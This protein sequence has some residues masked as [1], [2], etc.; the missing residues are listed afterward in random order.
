M[1]ILHT[2]DWHLGKIINEF[3]MLEDQAYIL[4]QLKQ[5][6]KEKEVDL[7]VIAGD[8]YDRSIP[9]TGAVCLF[10]Q[11]LSEVLIGTKLK[12]AIIPGNHDGNTR[13]SFGSILLKES[14]L[15][16]AGSEENYYEKVE[17]NE[18]YDLYLFP[19][20]DPIQVRHQLND[21]TITSHQSA[22][23]AI[24]KQID[25]NQQKKNI[26]AYH[27][28]VYKGKMEVETSE[29]ERPLAVGGTDAVNVSV[30]N[31]FEQVYLGHLHGRQQLVENKVM[32]SGSPLKYSF[33]EVNQLKGVYVNELNKTGI[34]SEFHKLEPLRDM[35]IIRGELEELIN[36][37]DNRIS[38]Y[39]KVE[40]TDSNDI[41]N[42][43]EKIRTKYPNAMALSRVNEQFNRDMVNLNDQYQLKQPI[44]QF[45][46]F[47][48]FIYD[49]D[50]NEDEKEILKEVINST[51][52][53]EE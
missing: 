29:S 16:I 31:Q 28:Y 30:F 47:Y 1:K 43:M 17:L 12:V 10:N 25:F 11:F 15:Y 33:S 38:D 49:R 7:L 35:R 18:E 22:I 4:K 19:Y 41:I 3:S 39:V 14:G 6:I 26:C 27:G 42:P 2:A 9:P 45:A 53:E 52:K 50:L 21:E 44:E 5:I 8:V 48:N 46:D 20:L 40:L 34:S 51:F 36:Q 23:E 32:Y 37:E 13:L 24:I